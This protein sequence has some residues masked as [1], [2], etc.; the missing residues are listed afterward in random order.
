M[1]AV[2]QL[3]LAGQQVVEAAQGLLFV[4]Q[5]LVLLSL[6]EMTLVLRDQS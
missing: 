4:P 1:E 3:L 5:V 2:A 6:L